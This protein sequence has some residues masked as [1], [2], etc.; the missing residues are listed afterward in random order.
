MNLWDKEGIFILLHVEDKYIYFRIYLFSILEIYQ[1]WF[2]VPRGQDIL[3]SFW[4]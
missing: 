2:G 3:V 4:I 1:I